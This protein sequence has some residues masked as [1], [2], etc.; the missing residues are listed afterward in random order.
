MDKATFLVQLQK[1]IGMLD[2]GE[3][4][5]II[6]EYSQHIDMKVSGGMTEAEAIEDFGDFNEFVR[7][8]LNAYHVKAPF[9]QVDAAEAAAPASPTA[10]DRLDD[11]VRGGAQAAG[12]A[13]DATKRGARKM[14]SAVTGAAGKLSDR[15]KEAVSQ[16]NAARA[17]ARAETA[18]SGVE[19]GRNGSGAQAAAAATAAGASRGMI[20][21]A[22]SMARSV[23]GACWSV[24]KTAARW[25][26]NFAVACLV[27]LGG[28][29]A[30]TSLFCLGLGV[31]FLVQGYPVAGLT[32]AAA[33]C[34]MAFAAIS[35]LLSR[36][37]V[38]KRSGAAACEAVE[39]GV[40]GSSCSSGGSSS[41]GGY[42][43]IGS[44]GSEGDASAQGQAPAQGVCPGSMRDS[45]GSG[46]TAPLAF[47]GF[48]G[49]E[50]RA[51]GAVMRTG[52]DPRGFDGG[53]FSTA[54]MGA[55]A[56]VRGKGAFYE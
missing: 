3:Q 56:Q 40:S 52:F 47:S 13:V 21:G 49:E 27:A 25:C 11:A 38:R 8:V 36:L 16:V 50:T 4:K 51:R 5:D 33:G 15:A 55:V 7:E 2:D 35:F 28:V 18:A 32:I 31:V 14:A 53:R 45:G 20:A 34:G 19:A 10:G 54:P 12:R 17:E 22:G 41:A 23:G 9:D 39:S 24:I 29:M 48:R 44:V 30:L 37:I 6:D 43:A 42:A 1:N 46:T 26:W